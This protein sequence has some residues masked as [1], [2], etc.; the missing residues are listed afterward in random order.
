MRFLDM[1]ARLLKTSAGVALAPAPDP[2]VTQ[3]TSH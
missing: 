1:L 2:R 3:L